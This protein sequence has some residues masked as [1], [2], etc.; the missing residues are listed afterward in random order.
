LKYQLFL[1]FL[2]INKDLKRQTYAA[3]GKN[4]NLSHLQK[5]AAGAQQD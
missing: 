5:H 3:T 2:P 1:L 4:Y